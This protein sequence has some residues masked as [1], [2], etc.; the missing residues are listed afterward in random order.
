MAPPT[1]R[2]ISER[3]VVSPLA[4]W[5]V[6]HGSFVTSQFHIAVK[7]EDEIG[8]CLLSSLDG[9]LDRNAL[10]EKLWQLLKSINALNHQGH[11]ETILRRKVQTDL[12]NNLEKL[13]RLGLL[14]V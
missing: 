11:D 8:R 9:T 12:E 4:R 2:V 3:P 6:Q 1:A 13:A 7:I 14:A 10:L 5:Q